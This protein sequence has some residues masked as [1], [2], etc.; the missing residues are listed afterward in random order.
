MKNKTTNYQ[1]RTSHNQML[2]FEERKL[3]LATKEKCE[4]TMNELKKIYWFEKQLLI[5]IPMLLR[6]ATTFELV[7][8]LT[9]L[10]KH[11]RDHIKSL[12]KQFPEISQIPFG[13][14]TIKLVP[15]KI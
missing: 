13:K 2:A 3:F 6:S 9:L 7:D 11:T 10:T 4:T 8:S 12:E 5:A 15:I 14:K 1:A